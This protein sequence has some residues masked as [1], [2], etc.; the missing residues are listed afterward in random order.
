MLNAKKLALSG[1]IV[2]SVFSFLFI[3]LVLLTGSGLSFI[4]S[5]LTSFFDNYLLD[6]TGALVVLFGVFIDAFIFF[7]LLAFVYNFL[8]KEDKKVESLYT[9][10]E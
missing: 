8:N 2:C 5:M 1:A 4:N 7:Y 10:E 6:W 9:N 3:A